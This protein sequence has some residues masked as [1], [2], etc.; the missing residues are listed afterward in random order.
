VLQARVL[1]DGMKD[2]QGLYLLGASYMQLQQAELAAVALKRA[3]E[4][5]PDQPSIALAYAEAMLF[6]NEG[7]L[8]LESNQLLRRLLLT[9]PQSERVLFLLG[10]GSFNG[11][12]YKEAIRYWQTLL[13]LREPNS[14]GAQVLRN[15]IAEA[16][17]RQAELDKPAVAQ[18]QTPPADGPSIAV[19]VDV[20]PSLRSKLTTDAIL[21]IFAKAASGPPMPLAAVRQ[22]V[23]D[24]PVQVVLDDKQAMMPSMKLSQFEQVVVGARISKT[25]DV[26]AQS[27]DLQ[28]LSDTLDL[29]D[30]AQSVALVID[31]IV[32]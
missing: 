6:A 25:G 3:Y 28:S 32:P 15:S 22:P 20:S 1:K 8:S 17:A 14:E 31:Q 5:A 2:P 12:A 10:W 29:T 27:G 18:K 9:N 16:Q 19:T 11:N 21:F 30:G 26:A 4:L 7:K 24:F 23:Q 13:S